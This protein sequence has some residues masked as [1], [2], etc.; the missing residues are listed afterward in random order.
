MSLRGV[1]ES[2]KSELHAI[3]CD[4]RGDQNMQVVMILAISAFVATI[5]WFFGKQTID[6]AKGMMKS[7]LGQK[8]PTEGDAKIQ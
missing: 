3:D 2:V 1:Y 5:V 6:W 4:E 7:L 8:A